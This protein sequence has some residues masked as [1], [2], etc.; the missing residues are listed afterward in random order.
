MSSRLAP[1]GIPPF[2]RTK[3][4]PFRAVAG[5]CG[6]RRLDHAQFRAIAARSAGD[7]VR[8]GLTG[9]GF[10]SPRRHGCGMSPRIRE[11]RADDLEAIVRLHED[12]AL[13]S[14][15][16]AWV[17]ANRDAYEAAFAAIA[18]SR[19]NTCMSPNWM[20]GRGHLSA[21]LHPESHRTRR[22]ASR[23]RA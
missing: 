9:A 18:G 12:D 3:E 4:A 19:D 8:Q 2:Q 16:D 11:A 20:A 15:G 23:S 5:V 7:E 6:Q 21:H 22:C 10:P 17:P 1:S 14:H 13:G